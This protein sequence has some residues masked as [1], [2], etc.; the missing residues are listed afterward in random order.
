MGN[1]GGGTTAFYASCLDERIK[2]SMPSCSVCTFEDSIIAMRH[3]CCNYIP[4]I[5]KYFNMGDLGALVAPRRLVVV[6]GTD[7]PIF[8]LSGVEKSFE[9]IKGAYYRLGVPENTV[10]VKGKGG[11]QFYPDD[12]WPV[13]H[14][15]SD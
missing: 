1:S 3:C 2:L 6:C 4:N 8:P 10:L 15:L 13:V 5:R 11:H 7:D 12:A 14:K 9:T